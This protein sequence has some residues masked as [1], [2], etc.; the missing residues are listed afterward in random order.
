MIINGIAR[1]NKTCCRRCFSRRGGFATRSGFATTTTKA[2]VVSS[3]SFLSEKQNTE[4]RYLRMMQNRGRRRTPRDGYC[5]YYFTDWNAHWEAWT[6]VDA[7]TFQP[8][9]PEQEPVE[10][11]QEPEEEPDVIFRCPGCTIS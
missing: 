4:Q 7:V 9:E 3:S 6:T 5:Y 2:V 10:P 11:E 1:A 8:V